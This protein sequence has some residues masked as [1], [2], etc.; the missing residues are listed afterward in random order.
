MNWKYLELDYIGPKCNICQN[1]GGKLKIDKIHRI[2]SIRQNS[3]GIR[4]N[5]RE[6]DNIRQKFDIIRHYSKNSTKFDK[7][8]NSIKFN[9]RNNSTKFDKI[10]Q[11]STS[12]DGFDDF[13]NIRTSNFC[14][15]RRIFSTAGLG[16]G[17]LS[18]FKP[19][20]LL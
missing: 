13:D 9:I 2:R 3:R 12:F 20:S 7:I 4:Q 14:R 10:R 17:L 18:D 16:G 5:S 1:S 8:Q 6:F 19:L 15:I 11:H